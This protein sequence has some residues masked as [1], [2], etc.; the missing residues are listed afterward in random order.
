M[1]R[2]DAYRLYGIIPISGVTI[3][4][5]NGKWIFIKDFDIE[6]LFSKQKGD[7]LFGR[8]DDEYDS[9]L[10]FYVKVDDKNWFMNMLSR[11]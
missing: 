3:K 4:K 1:Y 7:Q 6:C 5:A 2:L 8:W 10:E 11:K 9:N